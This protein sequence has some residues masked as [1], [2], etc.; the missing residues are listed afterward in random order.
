MNQSLGNRNQKALAPLKRA[1][2]GHRHMSKSASTLCP[3]LCVAVTLISSLWPSI[4]H[5]YTHIYAYTSI[6]IYIYI[7]LI[8]SLWSSISFCSTV[9]FLFMM[10]FSPLNLSVASLSSVSAHSYLCRRRSISESIRT[11]KERIRWNIE[12]ID[13]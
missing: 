6:Y 11:T 1:L 8:S 5:C 4:S 7:T 12:Y 2:G 3:S 9:N 10:P 13:I